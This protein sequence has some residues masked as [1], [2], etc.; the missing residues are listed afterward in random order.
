MKAQSSEPS[1]EQPP[2]SATG[3]PREFRTRV[4]PDIGKQIGILV[5]LARTLDEQFPPPERPYGVEAPTETEAT[6]PA[7]GEPAALDPPPA[8]P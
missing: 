4:D 2:A 3:M 5:A 7:G 6:P 1:P 8:S